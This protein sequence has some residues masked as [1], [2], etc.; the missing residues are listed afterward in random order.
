LIDIFSPTN[1]I[2]EY[3]IKLFARTDKQIEHSKAFLS[4]LNA[5][6]KTANR[7]YKMVPPNATI[8]EEYVKCGKLSCVACPHGPYYYAY[9]KDVN[10]KLRKKYIGTRFEVSC[11]KN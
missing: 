1:P 6:K 2:P 9:W 11:K 5:A 10:R 8:R 3:Y 7:N 4:R